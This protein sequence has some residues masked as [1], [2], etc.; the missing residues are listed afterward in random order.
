M[1]LSNAN[2]SGADIR[3][4]NLTQTSVTLTASEMAEFD[5]SGCNITGT[6]L[7]HVAP[8]QSNSDQVGL[9]TENLTFSKIGNELQIYWD[10]AENET[11]QLFYSTNGVNWNSYAPTKCEWAGDA[12]VGREIA[13][14]EEVSDRL[15]DSGNQYEI[16]RMAVAHSMESMTNAPVIM[17]KV[18]S[19]HPTEFN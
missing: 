9:S 10:G 12:I 7:L 14:S 17:F 19:G 2:L 4:A 11:Y 3:G 15:V 13:T 5:V 16:I 6:D 18:E 8:D 1:N